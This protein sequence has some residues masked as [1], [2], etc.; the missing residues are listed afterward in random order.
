MRGDRLV[1]TLLLLQARSRLTASELAA[2]LEIS[3]RTVRRDLE[4]LSIAGCR[5]TPSPAGAAA[6]RWWAGPGPISP[7]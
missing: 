2:E 5:S 1:A 3:L 6:G 7:A 4:A